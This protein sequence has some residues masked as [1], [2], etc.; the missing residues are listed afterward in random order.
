MVWYGMVPYHGSADDDII[1]SPRDESFSRQCSTMYYE[2]SSSAGLHK[3]CY[4]AL[5]IGDKFLNCGIGAVLTN[6]C[7][8]AS[9]K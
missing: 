3:N 5:I 9:H 4:I 8:E 2:I 1:F 6:S 7:S